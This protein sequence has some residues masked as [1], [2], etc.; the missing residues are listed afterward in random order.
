[1]SRLADAAFIQ[2]QVPGE[3]YAP[4]DVR[5]DDEY[6]GTDRG[7]GGMH[8]RSYRRRQ[9]AHLERARGC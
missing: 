4:V 5:P 1:M 2:R 6:I 8:G 3:T 9:T 7:M